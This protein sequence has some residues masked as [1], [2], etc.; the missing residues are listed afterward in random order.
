DGRVYHIDQSEQLSENGTPYV[1]VGVTNRSSVSSD[2][3]KMEVYWAKA[4]R[5]PI[6]PES[7][8][9]NKNGKGAHS[10]GFIASQDIPALA[11]GEETIIGIPWKQ[12]RSSKKGISLYLLAR[13]VSDEDAM[14]KEE[15]G[16]AVDNVINNN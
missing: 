15:A 2:K 12:S 11:P 8:Q 3:A 14:H 1:Y 9:A 7:F 6:W 10:G 4:D 16:P 13:I 5:P